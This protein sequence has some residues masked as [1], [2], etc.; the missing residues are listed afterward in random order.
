MQYDD[1]VVEV[2]WNM[3]D[4]NWRFLR[5]RDDKTHGNHRDVV[6][7][8]IESIVDGVELDVVCISPTTLLKC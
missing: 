3:E 7:S 4:R 6:K 2:S 8:V 1:R 5:F